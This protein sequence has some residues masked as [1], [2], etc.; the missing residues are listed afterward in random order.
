MNED[1]RQIKEDISFLRGLAQDDDSV[2]RASG[3]GLSVAG[4]VFGLAALRSFALT[5]G[6]MR[7]PSSLRPLLGWDA[8]ALFLIVLVSLLAT[9]RRQEGAHAAVD[10][11]SRSVWAGWAAVGVGYVVASVSLSLAGTH[12]NGCILFA[13]WGSGWFIASAAYR[14]GAFWLLALACYLVAI[15]SGLLWGTAYEHLLTSLALFALVALPGFWVLKLA[16][17]AA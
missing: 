8:T 12:S 3:I 7:W 14:R 5:V 10:A 6:W 2:L 16:R 17:P 15:A 4:C 9:T 11:R 1:V 13:F